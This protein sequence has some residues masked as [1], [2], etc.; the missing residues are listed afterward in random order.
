M[1]EQMVAIV[2]AQ[3]LQR[4]FGGDTVEGLVAAGDHYRARLARF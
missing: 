2:L 4:K 3:E 1:A